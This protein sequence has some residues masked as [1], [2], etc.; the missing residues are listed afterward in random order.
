MTARIP[1]RVRPHR[2]GPLRATLAVALVAALSSA[3]LEASAADPRA[4]GPS[5]APADP[6]FVAG[7]VDDLSCRI[8]KPAKKWEGTL[9]VEVK[10]R[11]RVAAEPIRFLLDNPGAPK[12]APTRLTLHRAGAPVFG[13]AGRAVQPGRSERYYFPIPWGYEPKKARIT[14]AAASFFRG[15]GVDDAPVTAGRPKDRTVRDDFSGQDVV[16]TEVELRNTLP[17]P[18]EVIV[19]LRGPHLP[20]VFLCMERLAPSSTRTVGNPYGESTSYVGRP[21]TYSA[22]QLRFD[23]VEVVDWSVAFD[24][25]DDDARD[26]LT[27]AVAR[28]Y[29]WPDPPPDATGR[30]RF[31]VRPHST[32]RG[33]P[34]ATGAADFTVRDGALRVRLPQDSPALRQHLESVLGRAIHLLKDPVDADFVRRHDVRTSEPGPPLVLLVGHDDGGDAAACAACIDPFVVLDDDRITATIGSLVDPEIR[35]TYENRTLDDGRYVPERVRSTSELRGDLTVREDWAFDFRVH[36]GVLMPREITALEN[37]FGTDDPEIETTIEVTD[38]DVDVDATALADPNAAAAPSGPA[39]EELRA[40]WDAAYRYPETRVDLEGSFEIEVPRDSNDW[41][42]QD[43]LF[44]RFRME[45]YDGRRGPREGIGVFDAMTVETDASFS[46]VVR[47]QVDGLAVARYSIWTRQDFCG[48]LSFDEA[49]RGT[50]VTRGERP[51]TFR[52]DGPD[53]RYLEVEAKDGVVTRLLLA[54]GTTQTFRFARV[55]GELVPVETRWDLGPHESRITAKFHQIGDR[56]FATEWEV[57]D[58]FLEGFGPEVFR[59]RPGR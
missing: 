37:R 14:V 33:V 58:W 19:A 20:G 4:A 39:A 23:D 28:R 31:R 1:P 5:A 53:P 50:T 32:A 46:D 25:E 21:G 44:G 51:D 15:R 2:I 40:I 49:F 59:Y 55:E 36:D 29:R 35:E 54:D 26:H 34:A 11:G 17:R 27:A 18:V 8:L 52:V 41:W 12:D 48:R 13:R 3:L 30:I 45:G 38:V 47:A 42:N 57:R 6:D 10:N 22:V 16:I 9:V 7:D 56:L 43:R 24:P